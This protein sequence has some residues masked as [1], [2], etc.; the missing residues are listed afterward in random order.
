[1]PGS[2]K[3]QDSVSLSQPQFA[4][5]LWKK[6]YAAAAAT[7]RATDQPGLQLLPHLRLSLLHLLPQRWLGADVGVHQILRLF[8]TELPLDTHDLN[9]R[10]RISPPQQRSRRIILPAWLAS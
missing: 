7:I 9:R 10:N 4:Y 5:R 2:V 3:M 1:M 8:Q 6:T